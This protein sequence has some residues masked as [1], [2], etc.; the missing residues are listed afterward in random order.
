MQA[1]APIY[2]ADDFT[3][4]YLA[5]MPRGRIWSKEPGSIIYDTVSAFGPTYERQTSSLAALLADSFPSNPVQL[6]FEWEETL[7]LPSP[8]AGVQ[9]LQQRQAH[10]LNKFANDGGQS[11]AYF[12]SVLTALGFTDATITEYA[13]FRAG[14]ST[15]GD[16]LGEPTIIFDWLITAPNLSVS[17]FIAG[18]IIPLPLYTIEGADELEYIIKQYAPA[19][20]N[21][22]FAVA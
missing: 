9:S 5:L 6:I 10:V 12:L 2:N 21:P 17:Y 16:S 19:H 15:S 7:G 22:L 14:F 13:P 11:V 3:Q 18:S 4:A 8:Y 1:A 20:T